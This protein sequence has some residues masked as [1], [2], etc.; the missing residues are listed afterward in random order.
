MKYA[1]KTAYVSSSYLKK[2]AKGR[3][4]RREWAGG[5]QDLHHGRCPI[6]TKAKV[7]AKAIKV[8]LQGHRDGR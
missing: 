3:L 1:G 2:D 7:T 8:V 6:R 5:H 4:R